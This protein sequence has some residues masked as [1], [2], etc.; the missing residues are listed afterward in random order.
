MAA[1]DCSVTLCFVSAEH[2]LAEW[3]TSFAP[4]RQ[5]YERIDP[6]WRGQFTDDLLR[7]V[8]LFA[9]PASGKLAVRCDYIEF[10]V[11]KAG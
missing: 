2:W 5:A 11:H 6:D 10:M 4:L 3:R 8:A 9:L 7:I 1:R